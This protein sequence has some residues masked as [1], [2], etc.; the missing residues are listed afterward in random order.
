MTLLTS[1]AGVAYLGDGIATEFPYTFPIPDVDSVIVY[2]Q[3]ADTRET[4]EILTTDDYDI[5]GLGT[6]EGG[7]VT[8]VGLTSE[9]YI[10]IERMVDYL[11]RLS[12]NRNGTYLP[13]NLE[14]YLD[15]MEMQIQQ[16]KGK[17]DRSIVAPFGVDGYSIGTDLDEGKV[18]SVGPN[19]TLVAEISAGDIANAAEYADRAEA[20][21]QA[22]LNVTAAYP[23]T[24]AALKAV[25]EDAF[26]YSYLLDITRAGIFKFDP[27]DLSA[28]VTAD[29]NNILYVAPDTDPTGT[30]GAWVRMWDGETFY[31]GW[32]GADGTNDTTAI[33][34]VLDYAANHTPL[35]SGK[36]RAFSR[37]DFRGRQFELDAQLVIAGPPNPQRR[38][39]VEI[40]NGAL[41]A[42]SGF[43]AQA[44]DADA[45]IPMVIFNDAA[46]GADMHHMYLD[47]NRKCSG[48]CIEPFDRSS[49]HIHIHH[50]VVTHFVNP[51]LLTEVD[52]DPGGESPPLPESNPLRPYGIYIGAEDTTTPNLSS[53]QCT[54]YNNLCFQWKA[55]DAEY[56]D[57]D[58]YTGLGISCYAIDT[59]IRFN[60]IDA[61]RKGIVV[62][63]WNNEVSFNHPSPPTPEL[64]DT[65]PIAERI[66]CIEIAD[67]G[68]N[69]IIGNYIDNGYLI[70][71]QTNQIII[72]NFFSWNPSSTFLNDSAIA[73]VATS[74][75]QTFD[76]DMIIQGNQLMDTL[77]NLYQYIERG[78]DSW[79]GKVGN[80]TVGQRADIG[81]KQLNI[82]RMQDVQSAVAVHTGSE[83]SLVICKNID[84]TVDAG[85]G[86]TADTL[87]ARIDGDDV[88]VSSAAEHNAQGLPIIGAP[89]KH[90]NDNGGLTLNETYT[91]YSIVNNAGGGAT[92]IL[93][94]DAVRGT[95][96]KLFRRGG[97]V[98]VDVEAGAKLNGGTT[99]ITVTANRSIDLVVVWQPG[100]AAEWSVEGTFT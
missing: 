66:A 48:I 91:G 61:V 37:V 38:M 12:I 43:A 98:I 100:A 32:A 8:Y 21:A 31:P 44:T 22:L 14:S 30:F 94:K 35:A 29:P 41:I 78:T 60:I 40:C 4:L 88:F 67:Y 7:E 47:C 16:L 27:S 3:D 55:D 19:R 9:K 6:A 51:L 24:I 68:N 58:N 54:I 92:Y 99:P 26:N 85:F 65:G 23:L 64:Y 79:V 33:K 74:T 13:S 96:M 57:W 1:A 76:D 71:Y 34:A 97:A 53:S 18:L 80:A 52:I 2:L 10:V 77:T 5:S 70:L 46:Y 81:S 15:R 36:L 82:V 11:Q 63:G 69:R 86:T 28:E 90:L 45:P 73:F 59:K 56:E 49:R 89:L 39:F 75:G 95:R 20:A 84:S 17:L 42:A 83:V 87:I 25:D 72:G 93:D 62:F 50:N